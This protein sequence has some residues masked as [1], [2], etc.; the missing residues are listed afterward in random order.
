ME[1]LIHIKSE[2]FYVSLSE[3]SEEVVCE[4][5]EDE[6]CHFVFEVHYVNTRDRG[7]MKIDVSK[8]GLYHKVHIYTIPYLLMGIHP[9]K[10]GTYGLTKTMYFS[11]ELQPRDTNGIHRGI[12]SFYYKNKPYSSFLNN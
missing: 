12:V 5:K 7:G 3:P 9:F 8:E 1:H 10:L 4:D 6:D 11:W 2:T